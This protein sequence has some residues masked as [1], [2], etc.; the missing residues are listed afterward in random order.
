M[1]FSG[2]PRAITSQVIAD[3]PC[4]PYIMGIYHGNGWKSGKDVEQA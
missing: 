2:A 4:C 1:R 3:M